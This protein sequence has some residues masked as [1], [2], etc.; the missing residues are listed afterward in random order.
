[1]FLLPLIA[2]AQKPQ[3]VIKSGVQTHAMM[4][5]VSPDS[6]LGLTVEDKEILILW[7]LRTGRQLQSFEHILAADFGLD[8][9]SID[10]VTSDYTFRKIDYLG[11]IISESPIKNT[12]RSNKLT[13]SYY[14]N[15]GL[16]LENGIIYTK[17][18]GYICAIVP[19]R[20][21]IEQHYS[22]KLNLVSIPYAKEVQLCKVPG[23]EI[24]KTIK[25][26]LLQ[27]NENLPE[28]KFTQFSADGKFIMAGNDQSLEIIDIE[29]GQSVYSYQGPYNAAAANLEGSFLDNAS[30]SPDNKRLLILCAMQVVMVDLTTKKEVWKITDREFG[31]PAYSS[32]RGI[33]HF[34][35]DGTKILIGYHNKFQYINAG[36]G[37]LISTLTGTTQDFIA[38]H[39][40]LENVNG[41]YIEQGG[42][43]I[44][45]NLASGALQSAA[46]VKLPYAPYKIQINKQGSKYYKFPQQVNEHDGNVSNFEEKPKNSSDN[47]ESV[48][49]SFDDKY[50]LQV[51][52]NKNYVSPDKVRPNTFELVMFDVKTKKIV[53]RKKETDAAVF[54]NTSKLLAVANTRGEATA[55]NEMGKYNTVQLL[56]GLTGNVVKT[57]SIPKESEEA[58]GMVFSP[59]DTYLTLNPYFYNGKLYSYDCQ[60]LIDINT[61]NVKQISK[62]LPNGKRFSFKTFTDDEKYLVATDASGLTGDVFFY[63]LLLEKWDLLKTIHTNEKS[64][65]STITI[66]K[67][68]RYIFTNT[69]EFSVKLW[70]VAAGKLLATLYPVPLTSDWAVVTPN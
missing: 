52:Q 5:S 51:W 36:D 69:D 14:R 38:T 22:E 15:A 48:S 59:K 27:K 40:L 41:L 6:K 53:W 10:V 23:G 11:K 35:D 63:D 56:D 8:N 4:A 18:K 67:N 60:L 66:S 37:K 29:S 32:R 47:T 57:F 20:Y 21:G 46:A 65:V 54:S 42:K 45:W 16:F 44:N 28:I 58:E 61:G 49:V 43:M 50:L 30:F 55:A 7:E 68:N 62:I 1:M 33:T 64:R 31:F 19:Q 25:F 34:S 2:T 26:N 39:Q 70:D 13:Y 24:I 12:A 3:L 17:D 9:K